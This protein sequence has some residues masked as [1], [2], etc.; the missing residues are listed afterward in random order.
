MTPIDIDRLSEP[1]LIDL[2]RRIVERLRMVQTLRSH[3]QMMRFSVGQR[4]RFEPPGNGVLVGMVT[5]Y[6]RKTVTVITEDGGHWNVAP[7]MLR[8]AERAGTATAEDAKVVPLS[9]RREAP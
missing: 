6:N 1:E 8:P 9:K 4:V 2:N 7:A 3:Q 5:R